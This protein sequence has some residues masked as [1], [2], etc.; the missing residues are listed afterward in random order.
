M[1]YVLFGWKDMRDERAAPL[2]NVEGNPDVWRHAYDIRET[3]CGLPHAFPKVF[4]PAC[5]LLLHDVNLMWMFC[6]SRCCVVSVWILLFGGPW[7]MMGG[8]KGR[9]IC[10]SFVCSVVWEVRIMIMSIMT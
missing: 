1:E 10:E 6:F 2:E 3:L 8:A 9:T 4:M 7:R 5:F